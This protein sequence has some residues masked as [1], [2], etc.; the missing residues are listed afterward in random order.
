ML[1]VVDL[2]LEDKYSSLKLSLYLNAAL[3]ALKASTPLA[4]P[5]ARVAIKHATSALNL[6]GD[7][8]NQSGK[9]KLSDA[10]KAKA[11]YR[12]AVAQLAVKEEAAAIADL[13]QAAKLVPADAAIQRELAAAKKTVDAKK[14]KSRAA[15]SKMFST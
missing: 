3:V 15:Y 5:D 8:A 14:A 4:A 9:R 7:A 11:L 6:D 12:R 1:P 13:E 10:E 2:E